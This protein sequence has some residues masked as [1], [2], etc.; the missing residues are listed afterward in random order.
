M[1]AMKSVKG[2]D[3][4][5]GIALMNAINKERSQFWSNP[6]IFATFAQAPILQHKGT[7]NEYMY[8]KFLQ[9][10][11]IIQLP[12]PFCPPKSFVYPRTI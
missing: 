2:I 5:P 6:G 11:L 9:Q 4:A 12:D 1:L 8:L 10:N 7:V 3:M